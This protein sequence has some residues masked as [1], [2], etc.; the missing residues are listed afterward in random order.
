MVGGCPKTDETALDCLVQ[1]ANKE[2]F[3][4]HDFTISKAIK[5]G[6]IHCL[7]LTD[8]GSKGER[9]LL[10]SVLVWSHDLG[11]AKLKCLF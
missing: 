10:D 4:D 3:S 9:G 2:A 8:D 11:M 1:G 6:A 7:C 5:V